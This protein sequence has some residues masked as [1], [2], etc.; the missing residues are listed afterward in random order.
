MAVGL[1]GDSWGAEDTETEP[2]AGGAGSDESTPAGQA[3]ES[4]QRTGA[5]WY[6]EQE[7]KRDSA[8]TAVGWNT[9]QEGRARRS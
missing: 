9:W 3:P 6:Q 5:A 7:W 2:A 4:V 8:A 1:E